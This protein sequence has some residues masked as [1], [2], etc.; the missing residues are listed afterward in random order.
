MARR[1]D[2]LWL[3]V[4]GVASSAWCLT[5]AAQFGATFDEPLYV[6]AGLESWRTGS[7][8]P[9]MS[10]GA[11][12]LPMDVQTLPLYLGER[13][14]G[15]PFDPVADLP[16]LLPVARAMTLVFWWLLL[17]YTM[18]L[19]RTFGGP[20][21]GRVAVTLVG[22]DP[23][24]LGHA[25]LA[26]TDIA[27]VACLLALFYHYWHGLGHTWPRRVLLPGILFGVAILAK[28][29]G[30]VFGVQAMI[31]LGVCHLYQ[32]GAFT[33]PA[34][35]TLRGKLAHIWHAGYAFRKDLACIL[36]IGFTLVF[37]YTGSDWTTERTFVEW[38]AKLPD[39]PVRSVM[40]PVS[41]NLTIFPN[42]GE[43]LAQQIKHNFRGHGTYLLG[44]WYQRATWK[45]FPVALSMK[46]PLPA[47]VLL[48]AVLA[49]RP[50]RLLSPP[51]WVALV[52]LAFSLNCRVQIGFRFMF[53]LMAMAYV[54]MG[55][56]V[57]NG[58]REGAWA[59]PRWLVAAVLVG[60]IS[61]AVWVWPNGLGYINQFWG[62]AAEGYRHLHD[63]NTDWGQG[64]PELKAWHQ[65]N[66][67]PPLAVWYYGTDPAIFHPP[68]RAV[69]LH[70][71]PVTSGD[72]VQRLAGGGFLA[73][74]TTLL[75]GEPEH[76][77]AGGVAVRWLKSLTP[78]SRTTHFFVYDLR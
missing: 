23:N 36:L 50:R 22:F 20:W 30:M 1:V 35:S 18:R 8:K 11:M 65:A 33:P 74:S 54:A 34:G 31:V 63:S 10:A 44:E 75:Y 71:R 58:W 26:T 46:V 66:G 12:T 55:V 37:A 69:P 40:L 53:T 28:A 39:G 73:V 48:A 15:T 6:R 41:Q 77:P 32:T 7:N 57:V 43:A 52:L 29:S 38:A 21:A 61:T 24:F 42:A 5:A 56:A 67:E 45:Y 64:L 25:A 13:H 51:G 76:T 4:V 59:V 17:A 19:G 47:L 62:G 78:A 60:L 14:R 27:V 9:L 49:L 72:D 70:C 3:L 16:T 2:W 68:F